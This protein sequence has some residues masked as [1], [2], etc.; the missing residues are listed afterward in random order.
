M[1][2]M[3]DSPGGKLLAQLLPK[4]KPGGLADRIERA[5]ARE[6]MRA[7]EAAVVLWEMAARAAK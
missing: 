4:F 2:G 1:Q 3:T 7:A 5:E 6:E